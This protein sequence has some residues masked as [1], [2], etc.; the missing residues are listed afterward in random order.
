M[1]KEDISL[2]VAIPSKGDCDISFAYGLTQLMLY[3]LSHEKVKKYQLL[4]QVG[5]IIDINRNRIVERIEGTHVLFLDDDVLP[6]KDAAIKLLDSGKDVIT[7][8]YFHRQAPFFPQIYQKNIK[9]GEL[10]DAIQRWPEEVFQID[11]CGMGCCL[12]KKSV[13]ETLDKPYFR[14]ELADGTGNRKRGEDLYFCRQV[15]EKGGTIWADGGVVSGHVGR[16]VI[17]PQ[18]WQMS[19]ARLEEIK[20][21]VGEEEF[22]KLKQK[23]RDPH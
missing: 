16:E 1:A 19:L 2:T 4:T 14:T 21:K 9:N 8:L 7:G 22:E 10:Y 6:P 17:G 11:A 20:K 23:W 5:S 13:F 18:H 3:T 15:Q 12:I